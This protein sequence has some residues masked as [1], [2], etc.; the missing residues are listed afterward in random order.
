MNSF[1]FIALFFFATTLLFSSN[2]NFTK[3]EQKWINNNPTVQLGADYKWPP[4][5]F[6]DSKGNHSGLA[7]EYIKLISTKSGLKIDIET[8]I[9]SD[10]LNDVK[11]KKYDGLSCAVETDER[12]KYLNFTT[13]YLKV[14]M[15]IVTQKKT[16]DIKDINSLEG[17]KVAINK[18]SYTQ[19]WM[20]NQ[21]PKIELYLTTSNENALDAV[22]LGKA[23]AYIGNLAVL[24]YI[25]N[26]NLLNNLKIIDKIDGFDTAVSI[27]IDKQNPML[28][29][30]IQKSLNSITINEHQKLKS[31]WQDNSKSINELL[32][33]T[34]K[35]QEWIDNHKVIKFVIDK[36]WKPIEYISKN[37]Q[38]FSGI[39][40]EYI[41][42]I[43]KKTGIDFQ[44]VKTDNWTD[45]TNKI[46]A[47]EVDLYSCVAA[48]PSREKIVNFSTVYLKMPMVFVTKSS[49]N[50]IPDI[51]SLYGKKIA[52]VK[53]Y[54]ITELVKKEHPQIDV[55]EVLKAADAYEMLAS[56]T[57]YAYIDLLAVVSYNIQKN[58][59]SN[60]KISGMS[61][62][63]S[64][65][66]MALRND[67]GKEGIEVINKALHSI[68]EKEKNDVF[69]KWLYVKYEREIDYT[70]IWQIA[71][72]L[73][74]LIIGS[75]FWNT[76]LSSEIK[77]RKIIQDE[78][79]ES[80]KI[81]ERKNSRIEKIIKI[82]DA[83]SKRLLKLN[84]ELEQAT[85]IAQNANKAKS[86][87][88]SNMS[89]EIRTPMNAILGF[90]E[91]LD[92]NIEDKKLKSFIK[93]IR[94]SGNTLLHL[95]NDILD[96]SKIESGKMQLIKKNVNINFILSEVI[97]IFKLQAEQKGIELKLELTSILPKS[98]LLDAVRV[99]EILIN[100]IGNSLKFTEKGSIKVSVIIHETYEHTSKLDMTIMVKDTGIGIPKEQQENIFNMFEQTENQDVK[101]YG[102]TGLG[103]AICRKLALLMDGSVEVESE[104][105][106]GSTFI[107]SLKNINIASIEEQDIDS[108]ARINVNDI[109]F[110]PATI[111][112]VD[113]IDENRS[114]VIESISSTK[115]N[116]I[117][118][119]NGKEAVEI[120][121][122]NDISLI[123]MDIR[124]PVMD[125]YSA[126]RII[127]ESNS[128]PIIA[129]TASIMQE[130]LDKL[131]NQ[132][133][134]GYLRKPVS[135]NELF[136]ELMKHLKHT[137]TNVL[138]KI[139]VKTEVEIDNLDDL[140]KF[141]AH[142]GKIDELY[143]EANKTN[144]FSKI[145]E[146][147]QT[148]QSLALKYKVNY[149]LTYAELL[150]EKID[151][152]EIDS[153]Q[154]MLLEY[155]SKIK[156]LKSK[157]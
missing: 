17:K 139:E 128:V 76:K 105:G 67:W 11:A 28:F 146:F 68:S 8:G 36:D 71:G 117:E 57:A 125:G 85:S 81:V 136:I 24:T 153:I 103:L 63:E 74:I 107:L 16:D 110:E 22:S 38:E 52:L 123:F 50:Y 56:E 4:F 26:K 134:N 130:E 48:T 77:K 9:W 122:K 93:T 40:S 111:L 39:S 14:P 10:V 140:A 96:L 70:L 144:D 35:Q 127:K 72:V 116:I 151:A 79:E 66:S 102:G 13:P 83:Q 150:L 99:K 75:L 108:Q 129:L 114:L 119:V 18:G 113:D 3:D 65:F 23:D 157:L 109:K 82:S 98:L 5:E 156:H 43:S 49:T 34:K 25:M 31:K 37:S 135:K 58:G 147:A 27:A 53:G 46:N 106:V 143:N 148:L 137:Q 21:Y 59:Y 45:A 95:I 97:E 30:I 126:T 47:R 33:F 20:E 120:A 2:P 29:N 12:K 90:A 1:R 55:I 142:I 100:L 44:L 87:F 41:K 91:L 32:T 84:E 118:A 89:H 101:K 6:A 94:S 15:V 92:D 112:V 73:M 155:E 154:S 152:F 124:M 7:A 145:S 132:R 42:I 115:L 88:L 138:E 60:L 62:Y 69:N 78:L 141:I 19:E 61:G 51:K 86:D 121:K 80:V 131:D 133:F 64:G 104:L 149:I 54:Y